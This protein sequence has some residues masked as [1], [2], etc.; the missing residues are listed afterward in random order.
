[1]LDSFNRLNQVLTNAYSELAAFNLGQS[2]RYTL[3]TEGVLSAK[4]NNDDKR[5][6]II[7]G[8]SPDTLIGGKGAD[9]LLGGLG[10]DTYKF[11]KGDGQDVITD[12]DGGKLIPQ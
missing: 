1:M 8:S 10:L 2:D 4:R 3:Q 6:L 11:D 12:T 5:D 7:G 9:I